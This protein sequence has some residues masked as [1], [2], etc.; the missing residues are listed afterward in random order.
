MDAK[1]RMLI[2]DSDRE[3]SR[4]MKTLF[5][6][7]DF[8]V[9]VAGDGQEAINFLSEYEVDLIISEVKMP[10]VGGIELMQEIKKRG[11]DT[12]VIFLTSWGEVGSYMDL[13]NMGAF[14]YLNKPAARHEILGVAMRAVHA[15]GGSG[16]QL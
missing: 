14:E 2:V 3:F 1:H 8:K 12:P 6:E 11:I 16:G 13:M 5:E 9:S 7:S 15:G 4:M 10:R